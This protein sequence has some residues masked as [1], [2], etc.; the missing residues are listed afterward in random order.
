MESKNPLPFIGKSQAWP[1]IFI[2]AAA[3]FC[4]QGIWAAQNSFSEGYKIQGVVEEYL[5]FAMADVHDVTC[6]QGAPDWPKVTGL[7]VGTHNSGCSIYGYPESTGTF[8]IEFFVESGVWSADIVVASSDTGPHPDPDTP[9]APIPANSSKLC[10][11]AFSG[12]GNVRV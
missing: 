8:R 10:S 5:G 1:S 6:R 4:S 3:M 11:G 9:P 2:F 12:A 7:P